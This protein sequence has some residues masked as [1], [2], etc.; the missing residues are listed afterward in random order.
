MQHSATSLGDT[1]LAINIK[2]NAAQKG[3]KER[4][5][6]P[7]KKSGCSTPILPLQPAT[8]F[9]LDKLTSKQKHEL[10]PKAVPRRQ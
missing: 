3:P 4:K 2:H 9:L 6:A 10:L 1:L 8:K 5:V 7:E